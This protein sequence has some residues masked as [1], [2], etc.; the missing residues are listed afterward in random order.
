MNRTITLSFALIIGLIISCQST[1]RTTISVGR[2]FDFIQLD[3]AFEIKLI[4]FHPSLLE[5]NAQGITYAILIGE[6]TSGSLP[7]KVSVLSYCDDR[8]F[9][10]GSTLMIKPTSNPEETTSLNIIYSTKDTIVNGQKSRWLVG[11]ENQAIWGKP[12][13]SP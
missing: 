7:S 5:C 13:I 8:K 4:E 12:I 1:Y 2:H 3:T 9:D 11:S 10:I 6:I